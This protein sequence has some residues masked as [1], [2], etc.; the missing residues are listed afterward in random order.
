MGQ[1]GS[2]GSKATSGTTDLSPR[3]CHG[4]KGSILP[5]VPVG[6]RTAGSC[7]EVGCPTGSAPIP[8]APT[9]QP[10][11]Q[12][13]LQGQAQG[14]LQRDVCQAGRNRPGGDSGQSKDGQ[15]R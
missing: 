14:S 8:C 13:E 5:V 1:K 10:Q 7:W 15:Q 2:W 9:L 12:S 3:R 4:E 11:K 6:S